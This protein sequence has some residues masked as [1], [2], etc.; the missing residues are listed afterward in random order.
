MDYE[1]EYD[2]T[3]VDTPENRRGMVRL[4]MKYAQSEDGSVPVY[5]DPEGSKNT[6]VGIYLRVL[7]DYSDPDLGTPEGLE[8]ALAL[9]NQDQGAD[10]YFVAVFDRLRYA[11][12]IYA[13]VPGDT[14]GTPAP[15]EME[16]EDCT[17]KGIVLF[18]REELAGEDM[19]AGFSFLHAGIDEIISICDD[20]GIDG[21]AINPPDIENTFHI[22]NLRYCIEEYYDID[23]FWDGIR[24]MGVEGEDLFPLLAQDFLGRNVYCVYGKSEREATGYVTPYKTWQ[25]PGYN[26]ETAGGKT[27]YVPLDRIK[28]IQELPDEEE[29]EE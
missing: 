20:L 25:A 21:M 17:G 7:A 16:Y 4:F 9:W 8:A 22:D 29:E 1:F 6:E 23:E 14:A 19:A 27:V 12:L 13:A 28:F 18:T 2:T 11:D 24:K 3:K 15:C 10:T 5:S 26:I